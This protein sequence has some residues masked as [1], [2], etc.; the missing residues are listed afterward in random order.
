[1]RTLCW[2]DPPAQEAVAAF[3]AQFGWRETALGYAAACRQLLAPAVG[4]RRGAGALPCVTCSPSASSAHASIAAVFHPWIGILAWTLVGM[5]NPHR[6]SWAASELPVAAAIVIATFIGIVFTRDRVRFIFTPTMGVLALFVIWMCITLPFS[7]FV[8]QSMEMWKR[9]MKID[10]M[11]FVAAAV[12]YTR[13]H[14]MALTWVLVGSLAFYGVKGGIFTI[15]TGG[16][17]LVWGPPDS[18]V[19]G[20][21]ELALALVMTIPLMRFLQLQLQQ[22]WARHAMTLAMLLTA[23]SALGTHSRGAL[24]ALVAMAVVLWTRT[25][26]KVASFTVLTLVGVALIAFMPG[27]WEDRMGTIVDYEQDESAMGR[28]NA[29]WM[30]YNLASDRFFGGGFWIYRRVVF[31][32]YAPD[33][34][35]HPRGAQHLLPGAGRARIRR[36]RPLPA[37]VVHGLAVGGVV[38]SQRRQAARVG[39][40]QRLGLDDA[41]EHR[42]VCGRRRLPEPRV[43]RPAVQPAAARGDRAAVGRAEALGGGSAAGAAP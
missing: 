16:N 38:A 7:I 37:A 42:R 5:V 21:N 26:H 9:V 27:Q 6:Y 13:K 22:R 29:W 10:F 1:M 3:A 43:L 14:I 31:Q 35:R 23:T 39:V 28:I 12:L 8:E 34:E 17:Y 41:G 18:F 30:A 15:A 19:E 2:R 32:Q 4:G 40:D 33:P 20:N 25:K 36:P 24:L 11:I